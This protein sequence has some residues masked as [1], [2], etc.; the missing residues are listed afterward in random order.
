M[1]L[2][3]LRLEQAFEYDK[4]FCYAVGMAPQN[5]HPIETGRRKA[6]IANLCGIVEVYG[7]S[8]DWL[9]TGEGNMFRG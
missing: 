2:S 9:F 3:M 5:L 6:S 8:P 4:D 7:V 1:A